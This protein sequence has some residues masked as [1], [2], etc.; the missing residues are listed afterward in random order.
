LSTKN[1][2]LFSFLL[3]LLGY[4]AISA[5]LT[6]DTYLAAQS[7]V[8]HKKTYRDFEVSPEMEEAVT[9]AVEDEGT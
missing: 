4:R 2:L 9:E 6:A 5:G 7:V 1:S 3:P 8:T